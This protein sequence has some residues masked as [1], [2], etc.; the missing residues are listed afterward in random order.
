MY[1]NLTV[2][3]VL[4]N[5][6]SEFILLKSGITVSALNNPFIIKVCINFPE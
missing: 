1:L 3:F 2:I 5:I 6:T 4:I